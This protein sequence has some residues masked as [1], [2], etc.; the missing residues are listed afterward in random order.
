M[1][2]TTQGTGR[3]TAGRAAAE[4]AAATAGRRATKTADRRQA[5]LAAA[6]ECFTERGYHATSMTDIVERS[7]A[8]IGSLYHH[9]GGKE[10]LA[11]ALYVETL[12]DWQEGAAAI[13]AGAP[14]AEEGIRALVHHYVGWVAANRR[15]ARYLL[16]TRPPEV[17]AATREPLR[18]TNR[19]FFG[20]VRAWLEPH[21]ERG[22][23]RDLPFELVHAIVLGPAQ[24]LARQWLAGRA[25]FDFEGVAGDLADAAWNAVKGDR[26]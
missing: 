4:R 24:E 21:V 23:I 8:S 25:R 10:E 16:A 12:R 2:E 13:L 1:K 15:R 5:I 7:G 6:L 11:A 17:A 22:R 3:A 14:G 26:P 18:E 20:A 19:A 9:F